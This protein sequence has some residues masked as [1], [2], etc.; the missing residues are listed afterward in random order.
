[1]TM[2]ISNP[3]SIHYACIARSTT[4]L[5]HYLAQADP[6]MESLGSECVAQAPPNHTVFS[7]TVNNRSYTFLIDPPFVFFAIFDHHLL[8]SQTLPFL[9]RIRHSFRQTL[10]SH[11]HFSHL[12]FQPHFASIFRDALHP[13]PHSS[14]PSLIVKPSEG[15]LKK[16]KRL[17]DNNS[18]TNGDSKD[19]A[20]ML[21]V[22]DDVVCLPPAKASVAVDR[23]KA[24]H[25]WKKHVW[26]VLLLDLFV[27]AVLFII[28]L[29]VCSGFQCMAY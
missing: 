11:N 12:S 22:S 6:N 28:W 27:C 14:P 3:E 21:D 8:K 18:C 9:H 4:I 5:A 26:V 15:L 17:L 1:M 13:P 20:A 25:V 7:H 2:M 19:A 10:S 24:K 23:Q 16:K 29:W